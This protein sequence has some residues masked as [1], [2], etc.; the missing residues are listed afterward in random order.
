MNITIKGKQS[1]I[2]KSTIH[3]N[4]ECYICKLL[5]NYVLKR[6][7]PKGL[8]ADEY[9][10]SCDFSR[11]NTHLNVNMIDTEKYKPARQNIKF[12]TRS[13]RSFANKLHILARQADIFGINQIN[14]QITY[15]YIILLIYLSVLVN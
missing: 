11:E 15:T 8:S 3:C 12:V 7:L 14:I 9:F 2:L 10:E 6:I 1:T 5:T 4:N 13:L